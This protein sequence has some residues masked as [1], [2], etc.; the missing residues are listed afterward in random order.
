[1]VTLKLKVLN[2]LE[3]INAY[4]QGNTSVTARK[5]WVGGHKETVTLRLYQAV[6]GIETPV[7][8]GERVLKESEEQVVTFTDLPKRTMD[9][10][11]ITYFVR[12]FGVPE[13]Y[14]VSYSP[15]R[16]TVTNTFQEGITHLN[17]KKIWQG[18]P[19]PSV[20]LELETHSQW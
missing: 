6:D 14:S 16:L 12:E 1:M 3:L 17:V 5:I 19:G 8:N 20:P 13:N 4:D 10:K 11:T 2:N 9:G 7:P 18:G 15:D